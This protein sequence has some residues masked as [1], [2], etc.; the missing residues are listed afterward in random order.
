MEGE[1]HNCYSRL[2]A[3]QPEVICL[4][5]HAYKHGEGRQVDMHQTRNLYMLASKLGCGKATEA[6]KRMESADSA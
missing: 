4:V 2:Q 1:K 6:V 5:A 3:Y